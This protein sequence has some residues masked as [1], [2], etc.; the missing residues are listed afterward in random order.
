[1]WR[2]SARPARAALGDAALSTRSIYFTEELVEA[3]GVS[4]QMQN[5][6]TEFSKEIV[7]LALGARPG[8]QPLDEIDG[9]LALLA[10][11]S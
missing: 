10:Q 6:G 8:L 1:V 5:R 11:L 4:V 9:G 3:L 2:G 7:S